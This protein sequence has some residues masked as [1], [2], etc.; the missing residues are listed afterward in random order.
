[1]CDEAGGCHGVK[2][3]DDVGNF[4]GVCPSKSGETGYALRNGIVTLSPASSQGAKLL[5]TAV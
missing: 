1:M 2:L 5:G 3:P 4:R